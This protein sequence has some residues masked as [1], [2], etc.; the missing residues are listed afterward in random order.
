MWNKSIN[1][2]CQELII[3]TLQ[4]R[5]EGQINRKLLHAVVP[6]DTECQTLEDADDKN[7]DDLLEEIPPEMLQKLIDTKDVRVMKVLERRAMIE[8]AQG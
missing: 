8:H 1:P 7:F 2:Y 5:V 6:N 3:T 4:I